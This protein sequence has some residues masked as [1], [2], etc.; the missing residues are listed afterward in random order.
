MF[1]NKTKSVY[2]WPENNSYYETVEIKSYPIFGWS[3]NKTILA[4]EIKSNNNNW[5]K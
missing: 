3:Q 4:D 1:I 2:Y 5:R